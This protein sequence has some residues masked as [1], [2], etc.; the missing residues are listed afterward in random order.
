M[1]ILVAHPDLGVDEHEDEDENLQQDIEKIEKEKSQVSCHETL[2]PRCPSFVF[3]MK[4]SS[5]LPY[6]SQNFRGNAPHLRVLK[7]QCMI[8]DGSSPPPPVPKMPAEEKFT[9]F[10]LTIATLDGD[11]SWMPAKYYHGDV[12]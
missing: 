2:I 4:Y 7:L 6:I 12:R 11:T 10:L 1:D 5:S 3:G 9:F 8:N